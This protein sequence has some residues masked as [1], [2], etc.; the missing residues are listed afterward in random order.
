MFFD[1]DDLPQRKTAK[2]REPPPT[3]DTGWTPPTEFPNLRWATM[4]SVDVETWEPDF[5]HGPGWGRGA[6]KGHIVGVSI[7]A[8][9]SEGNIGKWYF[10]VRH[11]VESH[12]NMNAS[13]VFDW[14]RDT[15]HTPHLPKVFANGIYDM[16]WLTEERIYVEGRYHDVQFAEALLHESGQVGLEHLGAKYVGEGK[17]SGAMYEWLAAAYGGAAT[18]KQRG[19]IYR[20]SPRLVGSYAESDADLPLRILRKQLPLLDAEGLTEVYDMEC[21]LARLLV[22]MRLAGVRVDVAGA[23][24]MYDELQREIAGMYDDMANRFG[25]RVSSVDS[26]QLEPL[27]TAAGVKFPVTETGKPSFRK[28]WLANLDHPLGVAINQIRER[29][30]LCST[31]LK[32]YI[33]DRNTNGYLHGSFHPLRSDDGGTR[34]G[35]LASSDPNLQNIPA[36]SELGRLIRQL[37]LHDEG[38]VAYEANDYSQIEY[39]FLAHFAIGPG[40]DAVREAYNTNPKTDYHHYTEDLVYD[41]TALRIERGP[42]KNINFGLL[43]G[44]G[45][46]KLARQIGVARDVADQLFAA[47]HAGAPYVQATMASAAEEAQSLGYI[48]TIMGR[49]S[50]FDLWEPKRINYDDRDTALPYDAALRQYGSNIQRAFTHKAINRRLQ[51]SSADM[52]K[53]AMVVCYERGLFEITGVPRLTVHDEL[54]FSVPDNTPEMNEAFAEVRH[55]ME[56]C[57]PLRVP[58]IVSSGRGPTWGD[59]G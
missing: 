16:G 50:R 14:L 39:R 41:K 13:N 12:L 40:S 33:L 37:F 28:D 43:Y 38:H 10:P 22:R 3:P 55:V 59:A 2:L 48:T 53:K 45:K 4:L 31:F 56:T 6:G 26:G 27:F 17:D 54:G 11:E 49:R 8:T 25:Y 30:K 18:G 42:I 24:R 47:Y 29:E 1:D 7:G 9:D 34:S 19:N 35:R 20:A 51:G 46:P 21:A 57:I 5:D 23:E 15:L 52:M 32:S 44:M 58:V 36:R